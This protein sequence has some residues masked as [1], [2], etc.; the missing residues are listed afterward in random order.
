MSVLLK[1]GKG[2]TLLCEK[3]LPNLDTLK[4]ILIKNKEEEGEEGEEEEGEEEGEEGEEEGKLVQNKFHKVLGVFKKG[5]SWINEGGLRSWERDILFKL[6][7]PGGQ[8][9][10]PTDW[11]ERASD[12]SIEEKKEKLSIM[13]RY[14]IATQRRMRDI[15][16]NEKTLRVRLTCKS[17]TVFFS[18]NSIF[19]FFT[20][21]I[22]FLLVYVPNFARR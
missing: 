8:F 5:G 3:H 19:F 21:L 11:K 18:L 10:F 9:L 2:G 14:V 15:Q 7:L 17:L 20:F 4:Q 6:Q 16:K 13:K 12:F 1:I 22:I